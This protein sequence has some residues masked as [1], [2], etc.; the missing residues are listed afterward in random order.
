MND[1]LAPL[2]PGEVLLDEFLKPMGISQNHLAIQI[3][4]LARGGGCSIKSSVCILLAKREPYHLLSS[5]H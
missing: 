5:E 1:K 4:K 3:A 2:H